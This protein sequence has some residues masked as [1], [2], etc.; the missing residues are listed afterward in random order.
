M[1]LAAGRRNQSITTHGDGRYICVNNIPGQ[2]KLSTG[3]GKTTGDV[4]GGNRDHRG[5]VLC[6]Y[7]ALLFLRLFPLCRN[8]FVKIELSLLPV[9]LF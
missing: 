6:G 4:T 5:K 8:I 3:R 1:Q 9:K 2:G 7:E